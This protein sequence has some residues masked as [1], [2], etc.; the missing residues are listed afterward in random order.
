[1]P[2]SR[3]WR[4]ISS[5]S[6]LYI[7]RLESFIFKLR[8]YFGRAESPESRN[9]EIHGSNPTAANWFYVYAA[10]AR[11][12]AYCRL[13]ELAARWAVTRVRCYVLEKS[14]TRIAGE[15]ANLSRGCE[16]IVHQFALSSGVPQFCHVSDLGKSV[17]V[18]LP[19]GR[20]EH[21]ILCRPISLC[22]SDSH[23]HSAQNAGTENAVEG[24]TAAATAPRA[25]L[26]EVRVINDDV[27][28]CSHRLPFDGV[29]AP[30]NCILA[31]RSRP[32]GT[33]SGPGSGVGGGTGAAA[34]ARREESMQMERISW[35]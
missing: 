29:P 26:S 20:I 30:P 18:T 21:C 35:S 22:R 32:T 31:R 12:S 2:F 17:S 27:E 13:A 15:I 24:S 28:V 4:A 9:W 23:V 19:G 6:L 3:S 34:V 7:Y 5:S 10:Y 1:M 8:D 33:W 11:E 25:D 14:S 16:S